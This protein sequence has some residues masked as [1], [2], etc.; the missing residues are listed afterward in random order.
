M[1]LRTITRGDT[2]VAGG[3]LLLLIAS[4]LP[5]Y[6][7]ET[8]YGSYS[9]NGWDQALWPLTQAVYWLGVIAAVLYLVP[10]FRPMDRAIAGLTLPQWGTA[11]GVAAAW[12]AL[13]GL[14]S[15]GEHGFG[16]FLTLLF[17][18]VLAFGVVAGGQVPAL[19]A[20]LLPNRPPAA[21]QPGA[22]GHPGAMG[23][24]GQ[25]GMYPQQGG[26][27]AYPYGQQGQPGQPGQ[28]GPGQQGPGQQGPMGAQPAGYG[29]PQPGP[30]QQQPGA[31]YGYPQ[32]STG[33][34]QQAPQAQQPQ[35]GG[36]PQQA[37][38]PQPQPQ[39]SQEQGG[40]GA[41]AAGGAE[42]FA[43]FWFAVPE[44]RQLVPVDNPAGGVVGELHPGVWYL[45]VDARGAALVAQTQEG[46]QGLLQNTSGIQRG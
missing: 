36:Q 32:P 5:Y 4:F 29:Y 1:N 43:P 33:A 7:D 34:Q 25:P 12:S 42:P 30:A 39:P 11:L 6:S 35:Q 22:M 13:W 28:P 10:R 24:P 15:E 3:A 2:I 31:G 44:V 18:L 16:A 14:F 19:K 9:Y 40:A 45:A 41:P 38:Q 27:Y 17:A 37:Q 46:A 8:Q 23:Q 26:A 20:P 21:V